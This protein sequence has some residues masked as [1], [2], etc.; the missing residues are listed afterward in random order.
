MSPL[1]L[2]FK[3]P[4]IFAGISLLIFCISLASIIG[5]SLY[6]TDEMNARILKKLA[7]ESIYDVLMKDSANLNKKATIWLK[8]EPYIESL[9]FV[10]F[11]KDNRITVCQ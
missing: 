4:F 5:L 2:K 6:R 11:S 10:Y 3:I 9:H 1:S 8:N 7:A